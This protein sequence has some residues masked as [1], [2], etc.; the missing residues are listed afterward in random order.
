MA[1]DY[2]GTILEAG[3][4]WTDPYDQDTGELTLNGLG[5]WSILNVR[6]NVPGAMLLPGAKVTES[7]ITVTNRHLGS[8]A[9]ELVRVSIQDNPYG[10]DLPIVL[11][12]DIGGTESRVYHG[13]NLS[14]LGAD[15]R[16]LTQAENGPDLRFRPR[17]VSGDATRI[18]WVMEHGA[19][20]ILEQAGPDWTWDARVERSGVARLG[21]DRDGTGLAAMAWAPGSGQ[22]QAMRMATARDTTLVN[23]G[24]P[25]TEAEESAKDE[26]SLPILQG[27]ANRKL[28]DSSRPWDTWSVTVRADTRPRL[29]LYQPGDWAR[30]NIPKD[31]PVLPPSSKVRVRILSIDGNDSK[32]VKLSVAPIQ[33]SV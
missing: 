19:V 28:A 18:E 17:Y 26:E 12:A 5:L 32:D 29:G 13:Y 16:E 9:R 14:W 31:H 3:P 22:E 10:G 11:P 24:Y 1:I 7:K 8:V 23:A 30:V 4:I 21:V 15:L 33:G 27:V 20:D 25:W 6:K 2:G